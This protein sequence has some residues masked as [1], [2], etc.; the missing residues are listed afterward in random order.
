M[1]MAKL[2]DQLRTSTIRFPGIPAP[3]ANNFETLIPYEIFKIVGKIESH[4]EMQDYFLQDDLS[5][6]HPVNQI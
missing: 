2:N 4:Y 5:F 1:R 6:A 3:L